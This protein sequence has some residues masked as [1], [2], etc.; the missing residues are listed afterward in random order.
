M[1]KYFL[2]VALALT[3]AFT[4][5]QGG[6][7]SVNYHIGLPYGDF[8][9]YLDEPSF[10]GFS[11]DYRVI[12]D[13]NIGVGG[14]LGWHIWHH[15]YPRTTFVTDSGA[16][17]ATHWRYTHVVPILLAAHYDF[18]GG[19]SKLKLSGGLGLGPYYVRQEVWIGLYELVFKQWGFG[20]APEL[21]LRYNFNDTFGM[22]FSPRYEVVF[23]GEQ[24]NLNDEKNHLQYWDF[25]MGLF[26]NIR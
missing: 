4:S 5:A 15:K 9:D 6:L 22:L 19:D 24:A 17:T 2:T 8:K 16:I 25:K 14:N 11:V 12:L 23:N 1:K 20:L 21:M 18:L 13:N 10:R 26:F 3:F 7:L